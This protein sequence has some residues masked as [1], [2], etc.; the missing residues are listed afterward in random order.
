MLASHYSAVHGIWQLRLR[1]CFTFANPCITLIAVFV[2]PS[3]V[4]VTHRKTTII[5]T[6]TRLPQ[7]PFGVCTLKCKPLLATRPKKEATA[8]WIA[9]SLIGACLNSARLN[10]SEGSGSLDYW[11]PQDT[12]GIGRIYEEQR[13]NGFFPYVATI[14]LKQIIREPSHE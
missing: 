10:R 12:E 6:I 2:I 4:P 11:D 1:H 13:K 8:G 14:D 9:S 5:I 3:S 7:I